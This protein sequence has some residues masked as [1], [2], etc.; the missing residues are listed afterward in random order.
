LF[1]IKAVCSEEIEARVSQS[2]AYAFFLDAANFVSFL[3]NLE[4]VA[5]E[6][7]GSWRWTIS[8]EVPKLGVMRVPFRVTRAE[9]PPARVEYA[10]ALA[11][12]ENYLRCAALLT[13]LGPALTRVKVSQTIDLRR[14]DA[15]SLHTL[16]GLVG[17]TRISAETQ[18]QMSLKL[19]EFMRAVKIKL[20][21]A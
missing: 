16:A 5:P 19:R 20:E 21:A 10:P 14:R 9:T 2:D 18:K 8:A 15:K 12:R 7:D 4:S 13:A 11:E 6:R 1:R 3:P 17:E